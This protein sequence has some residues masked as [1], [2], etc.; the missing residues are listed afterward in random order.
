M[1]FLPKTRVKSLLFVILAL[2]MTLFHLI[3]EAVLSGD[4]FRVYFAIFCFLP[5]MIGLWCQFNF[6]RISVAAVLLVLM[7]FIP[8]GIINPFSA[9]N[10][11]TPD[12][13]D[14]WELVLQVYSWV[15]VGLMVVH[16]L[17]KYR[18]EFRPIVRPKQKR[19]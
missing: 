6:V 7:I 11:D 17:G 4:E 8:P 15:I 10:G 3:V 5:L 2:C 18:S 16:I 13:P 1:R 19:P 14:A 12:F 9:I